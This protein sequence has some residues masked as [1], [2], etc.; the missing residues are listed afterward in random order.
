MP[1]VLSGLTAK[2]FFS[3]NIFNY[4]KHHLSGAFLFLKLLLSK[5]FVLSR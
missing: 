1:F 2:T 3:D 5:Q 4:K